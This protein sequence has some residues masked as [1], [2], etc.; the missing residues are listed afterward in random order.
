[1]TDFV[2]VIYHGPHDET[3]IERDE[4]D[5]PITGIVPGVPF[6]VP[7]WLFEGHPGEPGIWLDA[8]GTAHEFTRHDLLPD[9]DY[10]LGFPGEIVQQP[11]NEVPPLQ[12]SL[13]RLASEPPPTDEVPDGTVTELVDWIGDNAERAAEALAAEKAGQKRKGVLDVAQTIID[14]AGE[15]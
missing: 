11:I 13:Y 12:D 10:P 8:D 14:Q 9:G 6:D 5:E 7:T 1:M 4:L 2:T 15:S 3:Y